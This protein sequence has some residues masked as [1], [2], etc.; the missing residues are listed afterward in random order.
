VIYISGEGFDPEHRVP[1]SVFV[2]KPPD[3]QQ[4]TVVGQSRANSAFAFESALTS[5]SDISLHRT[6]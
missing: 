5:T 3:A 2:A 6:R 4:M 1:G